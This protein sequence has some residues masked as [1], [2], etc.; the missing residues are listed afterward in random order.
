MSVN[1]GKTVLITGASRGIGLEISKRLEACGYDLLTPGRDILDLSDKESV[2]NYCKNN[3]KK[4]D[5]LINNA[6]INPISLVEDIDEDDL[7]KVIQ[8]NLISPIMLTKMVLPGMKKRNYGRIINISS[9]WSMSGKSGRSTYAATK[10]G[11]AGFSRHL[12]VEGAK[13]N[14]LVNTVAPGFVNTEL[15]KQ[16][17][18]EEIIK[19]IS[20]SIPLKRLAEPEEIAEFI[21]FLVSDK[22]TYIT[23][24]EILIDGGFTITAE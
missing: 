20:N 10:S 12:A 2:K 18:S 3:N 11:L 21:S 14:I 9:I 16:N 13:N 15:T 24:Q 7:Y 5:V 19:S 8:V 1:Q 17:N 4:I 22:N 6:G 23:G